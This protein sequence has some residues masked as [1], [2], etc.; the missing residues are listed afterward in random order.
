MKIKFIDQERFQIVQ[1]MF[2]NDRPIWSK[3]AIHA[4]TRIASDRLK[5][6][7]PALAYYY[8]TG[9]WRNQWVRFGYDPR[10]EPEAGMYQTLDYRVR[11]QGKNFH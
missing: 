11:L 10:K 4:I 1:N 3:N 7:L 9:P 8:T 5:F 2:K 6:I